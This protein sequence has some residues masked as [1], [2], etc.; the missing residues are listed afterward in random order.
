MAKTPTKVKLTKPWKNHKA[1]E[2]ISVNPRL[3]RDLVYLGYTPKGGGATAAKK[4]PEAKAKATTKK[5][6]KPPADKMVSE[7]KTK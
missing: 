1:G 6:T 3:Y 4:K 5:V 2:I 7:K